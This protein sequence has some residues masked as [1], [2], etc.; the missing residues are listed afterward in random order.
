MLSEHDEA[1]C[2]SYNE[3][4]PALFFITQ[5]V[6]AGMD[7]EAGAAR[8]IANIGPMLAHQSITPM[9]KLDEVV[10]SRN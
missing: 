1:F 10:G 4:N 3:L 2:D 7:A 9:N 5:T 6:V 8:A